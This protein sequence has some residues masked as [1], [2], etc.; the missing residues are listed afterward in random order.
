MSETYHKARLGPLGGS[1]PFE[2]SKIIGMDREDSHQITG[3]HLVEKHSHW[4]THHV[5]LERHGSHNVAKA[6]TWASVELGVNGE[7][8]ILAIAHCGL[9]ASSLPRSNL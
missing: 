5:A 7:R 2:A 6:T 1:G 3:R 9:N 4:E 8:V